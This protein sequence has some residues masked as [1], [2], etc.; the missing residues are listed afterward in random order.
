MDWRRKVH[1]YIDRHDWYIGYYRGEHFH[2]IVLLTIVLRVQRR[3]SPVAFRKLPE[4]AGPEP[5][6]AR[7]VTA[8]AAAEEREPA[9][10]TTARF[11][12]RIRNYTTKRNS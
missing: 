2:F 7:N 4:G 1:V 9:R 11:H 6:E 12:P 5:T 8:E 10:Q 3:K